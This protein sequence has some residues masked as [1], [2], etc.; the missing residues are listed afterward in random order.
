MIHCLVEQRDACSTLGAARVFPRI[1][2]PAGSPVISGSAKFSYQRIFPS[3]MPI[4]M[5]R[6]YSAAAASGGS[7]VFMNSI[8]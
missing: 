8:R 4:L 2:F 1:L 3:S 5:P 6:V 7:M